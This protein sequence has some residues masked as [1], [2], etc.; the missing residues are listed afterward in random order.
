MESPE[1]NKCVSV[2]V[3]SHMG[4][5]GSLEGF[6]FSVCQFNFNKMVAG[7]CERESR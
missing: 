1:Y 5:N 6:C 3:H 2:C 7:V 4:F